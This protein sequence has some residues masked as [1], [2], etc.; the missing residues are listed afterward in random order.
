MPYGDFW[1]LT[2][3]TASDNILHNKAFNSA[4]NL[5][6]MDVNAILLQWFVNFW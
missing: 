1:D 4:K 6:I 2:R 3:T 5:D